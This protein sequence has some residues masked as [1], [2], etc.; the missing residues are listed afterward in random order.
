MQHQQYSHVS[1]LFLGNAKAVI[2]PAKSQSIG[3]EFISKCIFL[4]YVLFYFML[5]LAAKATGS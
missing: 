4:G 2:K 5:P 1:I 3:A